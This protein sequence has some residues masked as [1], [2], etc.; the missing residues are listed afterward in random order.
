M[1]RRG[2]YLFNMEFLKFH[3]A[4][5]TG[6][7]AVTAVPTRAPFNL[8]RVFDK[9]LSVGLVLLPFILPLYFL[10][11]TSE[12]Y[13]FNKQVLLVFATG[14]L[15]TAWFGK[16][17]TERELRFT[18]TP[19]EI[20]ILLFYAVYLVT[21]AA[22]VN[23]TTSI[24]G[25]FGRFD[26][27][28]LNITC[29]VLLYF[30]Y[31]NNV[32]TISQIKK[33]A[34]AVSLSAITLALLGLGVYFDLFKSLPWNLLHSRYFT[35]VGSPNILAY[36]LA[37][38]LP[39]TLGLTAI[40]RG[41]LKAFYALGAVASFAYLALA[42]GSLDQANMITGAWVGVAVAVVIFFYAAREI[43]L[44]RNRAL[45][46]TLLVIFL[47]LST[48]VIPAVRNTL[49]AAYRDLPRE[50]NLDW[51]STWPIA[52]STLAERP[53][54]GSGPDTFLFDFTR[55]RSFS[56]NATPYWNLRFDRGASEFLQI[57]TTLGLLG[58]AAFIFL[59]YRIAKLISSNLSKARELEATHT[60]AVGFAAGTASILLVAVFFSYLST[61]TAFLLWLSLA[62]LM[63]LWVEEKQVVV[64]STVISVPVAGEPGEGRRDIFPG[65]VFFPTLVI[66]LLILFLFGK[67]FWA[68]VTF[69]RGLEAAQANNGRDT[70]S[71]QRDALQIA[72]VN[73]G[74]WT[75]HFD[76]DVYY[77]T[78]SGTNLLLA[79]SLA[80]QAK[81]DTSLVNQ[82]VQ[83][84]VS[85][86]Q[87]AKDFNPWDVNNW[88]QLATI[89]RN[90]VSYAQGADQYAEQ[91][92]EAAINLDPTNARLYDALGTFYSQVK[93][94][95]DAI[96]VLGQATTLKPDLAAAHFDRARALASRADVEGTTKD[97][98][99]NYLTASQ[100]EYQATLKLVTSGS[101]DETQVKK[102]LADVTAKLTAL[103]GPTTTTTTTTSPSAAPSGTSK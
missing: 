92:Y 55:F 73:L 12:Y 20:P 81:P 52:A 43:A 96:R 9:I 64:K 69:E 25:H 2:P 74:V 72:Q 94:Y 49:P 4:T 7:A 36:Y 47:A 35:P 17:W 11:T 26:G 1:V 61:T 98:Q 80:G 70:Y 23:L 10:A 66:T 103:G 19:L 90:I 53:I 13:E 59:I 86:A 60:I 57:L 37:A 38:T 75:V 78:F 8:R 95:D 30:V 67:M 34:G 56:L 58:L 45:F 42:S 76:R 89:Y 65:V 33:I 87:T 100:Q 62:L 28:L 3:T 93:R 15:L 77:R 71:L 22:S 91:S 39:V 82:F 27:G 6:E 29:Y 40:S 44:S 99:R 51:S 48:L 31:V 46:T 54:F 79:N 88:E 21:T 97:A 85:S 68:D 16:M 101:A 5:T 14:I 63:R 84:A 50:V 18:R 41:F 32:R 24:L 102:E 83:Q